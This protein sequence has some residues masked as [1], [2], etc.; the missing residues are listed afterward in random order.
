MREIP[1]GELARFDLNNNGARQPRATR[2]GESTVKGTGPQ[3]GTPLDQKALETVAHLYREALRTGKPPAAT[4]AAALNI[5][6]STAAKR[7][8]AARRQNLLG[9][10]APGR[11]G[12]TR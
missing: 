11:K 1:I 5:A 10:T 4:V 7:I 9:P 12:E 3:R 8:M 6:P 2:A